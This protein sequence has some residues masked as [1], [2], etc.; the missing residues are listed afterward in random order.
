M[1]TNAVCKFF[2][3]LT[4]NP[5][6]TRKGEQESKHLPYKE[7]GFDNQLHIALTSNN[8]ESNKAYKN[9]QQMLFKR[10]AQPAELA[11]VYVLL[12]SDEASYISG[13]VITVIGDQPVLP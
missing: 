3:N 1:L 5:F 2:G 4:P 10:P 6:P 11:P 13:A 12:A 9:L 7:M 8:K